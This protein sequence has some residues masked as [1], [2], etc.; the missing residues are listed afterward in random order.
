MATSLPTRP[1]WTKKHGQN[2]YGYKNHIGVDRKHK[3]IRRY[4]ETDELS[5]APRSGFLTCMRTT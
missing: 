3:L 4:A 2:F 1:R 5:R